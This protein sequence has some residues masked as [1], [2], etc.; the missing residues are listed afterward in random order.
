MNFICTNIYI[1]TSFGILIY[2]SKN[3]KEYMINKDA[4]IRMEL[5]MDMEKRLFYHLFY[6]HELKLDLYF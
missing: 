1:F 5:G 4:I 3:E 2:A 6:Q